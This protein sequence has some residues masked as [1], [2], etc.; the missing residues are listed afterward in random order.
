MLLLLIVQLPVKYY[1]NHKACGLCPFLVT[2]IASLKMLRLNMS[3][4]MK[5]AYRLEYFKCDGPD[6]FTTYRCPYY[7]VVYRAVSLWRR[8]PPIEHGERGHALLPESPLYSV[9]LLAYL[10]RLLGA[11]H[12]EERLR[13]LRFGD[14]GQISSQGGSAWVFAYARVCANV[15]RSKKPFSV[16]FFFF[17]TFKYVWCILHKR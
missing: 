8:I 16:I 11:V 4:V 14:P 15:N 10:H 6:V 3:R 13:E 17:T 12:P 7:C 2:L 1:I 9:Y 5:A